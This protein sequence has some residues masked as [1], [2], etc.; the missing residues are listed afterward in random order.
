MMCPSEQK[1][2]H[3]GE[4]PRESHTRYCPKCFLYVFPDGHTEDP[5]EIVRANIPS[6]PLPPILG[7]RG[8]RTWMELK[9]SGNPMYKTGSVEPIDLYKVSGMFTHFALCNIIKYAY[10]YTK[11]RQRDRVSNLNKIIHYAQ[12]LI[13]QEEE[14]D[15]HKA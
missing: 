14:R 9:V 13:A 7:G 11:T 5:L 10:R 2:E 15:N 4:L 1:C 3:N 8:S 12:L 6:P